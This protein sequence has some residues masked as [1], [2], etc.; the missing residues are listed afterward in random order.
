M[1]LVPMDTPGVNILRP[2]AVFGHEHDHA[3]IIFDNVRVPKENMILGPGR[4]FEIAQGRLGPGRIHHC[5]RSIGVAEM[6]LE[7][8]V[9]RA[10]NRHAFGSVV[11]RKDTIRQIVANA[12]I[13]ITKCRQLTYLAAVMADEKGFKAARKYIAMIKYAVPKMALDVVDEA[14][15][16]HGAHGVSQDS[17]LS[18]LYTSLRTLRVADGPDIVHLNTIAKI[19]INRTPSPL[20]IAVSGVNENIK[21]YG[22]FEHVKNI[23]FPSDKSDKKQ[24]ARL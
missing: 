16:V 12:R 19:E 9:Y 1:I 22:K 3:E 4:G 15:Q 24:T 11:S 17:R 13:E 6:A 18:D 10:Q 20:A 21:K 23:A 2:L 7:A 8:M 5:M 14:I